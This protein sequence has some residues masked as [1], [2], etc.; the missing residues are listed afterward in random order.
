M[1]N[2]IVDYAEDAFSRFGFRLVV[3]EEI[4]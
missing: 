1:Q 4:I 3:P 2:Y